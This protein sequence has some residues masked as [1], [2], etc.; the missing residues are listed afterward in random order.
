MSGPDRFQCRTQITT[1]SAASLLVLTD[2]GL[3]SSATRKQGID[4]RERTR[5][6]MIFGSGFCSP[7]VLHRNAIIQ[8]LQPFDFAESFRRV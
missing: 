2:V 5:K 7:Y 1:L 8:S 4:E 6:A 3:C